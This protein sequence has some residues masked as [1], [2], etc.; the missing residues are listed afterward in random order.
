M[1]KI[2]N[3]EIRKFNELLEKEIQNIAFLN[4]VKISM[5]I[6][7]NKLRHLVITDSVA[8]LEFVN[9]GYFNSELS[10]CIVFDVMNRLDLEMFGHDSVFWVYPKYLAKDLFFMLQS[11]HAPSSGPIK[12]RYRCH[13]ENWGRQT[14]YL[15]LDGKIVYH[16][17]DVPKAELDKIR[18]DFGDKA[19][20]SFKRTMTTDDEINLS[21]ENVT[22]AMGGYKDANE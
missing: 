12:F 10:A 1:V 21:Y 6:K 11:L 16:F 8:S 4:G 9:Y 7:G 2:K 20:E 22:H 19:F 15:C 3:K 5:K 18:S 13:E 17:D 14:N